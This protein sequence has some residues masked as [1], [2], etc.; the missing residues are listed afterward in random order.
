[1]ATATLTKIDTTD[2]PAP[3]AASASDLATLIALVTDLGQKVSALDT[4]VKEQ[5]AHVPTFR[6]MD[7]PNQENPAS[8]ARRRAAATK[9]L[10]GGEERQGEIVLPIGVNGRRIEENLLPFFGTQYE[11]G[12]PVRI[13]RE[14][15][16]EG[17]ARTWGEILDKAHVDGEGVILRPMWVG[18]LRIWKYR[19]RVPGLTRKTGDGFLAHELIAA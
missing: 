8:I 16:R 7:R 1:M 2:T 19:V 4:Q 13:N 6:P 9:G 17:S 5:R 10:V 18:K 11:S 14:A 12:Q 3:E 15:T